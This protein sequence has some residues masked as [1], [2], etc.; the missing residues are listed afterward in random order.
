MAIAY[1]RGTDR[2]QSTH[3]VG[4]G[5]A[6]QKFYANSTHISIHPPRGGWDDFPS[7]VSGKAS[8]ISIHPPRGGWDRLCNPGRNKSCHFNPPTPWGV[9]RCSGSK[10][11]D[12]GYFNP[13]TPWGVGL[14][15]NVCYR[16]RFAFQSTHPVGGG[17][18]DY[19]KCRGYCQISIHPPRGGWDDIALGG[20]EMLH[21]S[22][23]PPRGGWDFLCCPGYESA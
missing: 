6:A 3:P 18:D 15:L 23:H 7:G 19:I 17:T 10:R 8:L 12:S 2:F 13:P 1:Y 20:H 14:L 16:F 9:G 21:I 5:T 22:I 4:G 11:P